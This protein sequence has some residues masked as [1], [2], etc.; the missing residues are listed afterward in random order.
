[1]VGMIK[2]IGIFTEGGVGIGLGHLSRCLAIAYSLQQKGYNPIFFNCSKEDVSVVKPFKVSNIDW[3]VDAINIIK[4]DKLSFV[5]IDSYLAS[6][7]VYNLISSLL[8]GNMLIIDDYMR[9]VYPK[10]LVVN[11]SMCAETIEYPISA[12]QKYFLGKD[13][14]ILRPD[15]W[16]V[17]PKIIKEK[18]ENVFITLGGYADKE[19]LSKLALFIKEH[20]EVQVQ[21]LDSYKNQYSA[22]QIRDMMTNAD[23]CISGGGQTMYELARMGV[24]T[25]SVTLAT[26]QVLNIEALNREGFSYSAGEVD[27]PRFYECLKAGLIVMRNKETRMAHSTRGQQIVDGKG[28]R[29]LV[30]SIELLL[31]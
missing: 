21:I 27:N 22:S 8:D 7:E 6:Q 28:V 29:R 12:G 20:M 5:I 30:G 19:I 17:E 26:N 31:Y 24:P 4:K 10:S 25:I 14:I 13:Y 16:K 2:N 11:P 15:F 18:I 9:L 23:L 3:K 1:M